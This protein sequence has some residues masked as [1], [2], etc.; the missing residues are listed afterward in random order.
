MGTATDN[1]GGATTTST[2]Q[3]V[4]YKIVEPDPPPKNELPPSFF[5]KFILHDRVENLA[6]PAPSTTSTSGT[7]QVHQ[8]GDTTSTASAGQE[9]QREDYGEYFHVVTDFGVL[10]AWYIVPE[11]VEQYLRGVR[12]LL[13]NGGVYVVKMDNALHND[14]KRD[15]WEWILQTATWAR[16]FRF[17]TNCIRIE[18]KKKAT[19]KLIVD[20][21]V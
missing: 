17:I 13:R 6:Q 4:I 1:E 2:K 3:E 12:R 19:I 20:K 10:G 16:C 7:H 21:G 18:F 5:D 9:E 14:A 15:V 11:S 8:G